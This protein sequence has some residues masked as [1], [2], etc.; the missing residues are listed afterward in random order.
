QRRGRRDRCYCYR[1][2][3]APDALI[4]QRRWPAGIGFSPS[5][6]C[7]SRARLAPGGW[8]AGGGGVQPQLL[9]RIAGAPCFWRVDGR[10]WW[11]S[12][13]AAAAHRGRSLLL[14]GGWPV[15]VG[16]SPSCCCASR[17]LL[18]SGGWMAGGGGVQP[19]LLLRIAGAPCFWR[20]D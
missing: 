12:A 14:A 9:L 11:G 20:V 6:C 16:F 5:C 15:V 7:A 17:A 18:A 19:Q 13:P 4:R 8:M 3:P 2:Q 10:W 1:L